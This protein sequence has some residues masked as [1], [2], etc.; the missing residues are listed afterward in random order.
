MEVHNGRSA[1]VKHARNLGQSVPKSG[2]GVDIYMRDLLSICATTRARGCRAEEK[3][4]DKVNK[5]F[6]K[7]T[8]VLCRYF[9]RWRRRFISPGIAILPKERSYTAE[10]NWRPKMMITFVLL[11]SPLV[12]LHD[13][14]TVIVRQMLSAKPSHSE[15]LWNF[16][17]YKDR[18]RITLE[19]NPHF[20]SSLPADESAYTP[21]FKCR[22]LG[23]LNM[24]LKPHDTV[25]VL[26]DRPGRVFLETK[27][28]KR[29]FGNVW[30]LNGTLIFKDSSGILEGEQFVRN[31]SIKGNWRRYEEPVVFHNCKCRARLN[32]RRLRPIITTPLVNPASEMPFDDWAVLSHPSSH[33]INIQIYSAQRRRES[34]LD[35]DLPPPPPTS[36]EPEYPVLYTSIK[37]LN[38][39]VLL[40][41]FDHYRP[42]EERSRKLRLG[43]FK[44]AHV[45]RRWRHLI[46]QSA[47]Y[48]D[49]HIL[50]TKG[51]PVVDTLYLL[52]P[53]PL[54]IDFQSTIIRA[55]DE[56]GISHALRLHNRV[57]RIDLHIP[58][59]SLR[60]SLVLL[61]EPFPRLERLSLSS[62]A[63]EATNLIIPKTFR[64]PNL[65]Y[66][67]LLGINLSNELPLLSSTVSLVTLTLENIRDSGYFLPKHLITCL[68][69]FR[70]LEELSIGFSTPLSHSIAERELLDALESPVTLPKLKIFT[71]SGVGAYLETLIAQIRAP[72]LERLNITLFDQVAF[73]LPH[74]SHFTNTTESLTLPVAEIIFEREAVAVVTNHCELR[75]GNIPSSFSLRVMCNVFDRQVDCAAQ[76]C[77]AL[78]P[79][80]SSVEQ[81]TLVDGE[82]MPTNWQDSDIDSAMWRKL[83]R[84]FIGT[85]RLHICRVLLWEIAYALQLG[86]AGLDPGL[87]PGLQELAPDISARD[88]DNSFTSFI[89]ARQV[90]GRPCHTNGDFGDRFSTI[91][92]GILGTPT[93]LTGTLYSAMLNRWDPPYLGWG[94]QDI[95][96]A[97][98]VPLEHNLPAPHAP[99]ARVEHN[100]PRS[101]RTTHLV[102]IQHPPPK[103]IRSRL[104]PSHRGAGS[105]WR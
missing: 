16:S 23:D 63:D 54:V 39:D 46:Y 97:Q 75:L 103:H 3:A 58:P 38:D 11:R 80:L 6:E 95:L 68:R 52:P 48:L 60:K 86:D 2:R 21:M 15:I 7:A 76:I 19:Q 105:A 28:E 64:A 83:L 36:E 85:K 101:A 8:R 59:S 100:P 41:I 51:A 27:R 31:T 49:A 4:T 55:R 20:Y 44:L 12:D 81:L 94:M 18:A 67:K 37:T 1:F 26:V 30:M 104:R 88:T 25:Y 10:D 77:S 70:Q 69:S 73:A 56:L 90:A 93:L 22:P 40:S 71:F 62:T 96:P 98:P 72:I 99:P 9:E 84:P 91:S 24:A 29:S 78:R 79:A 89:D 87:L 45:C 53:L 34:T 5:R 61:D 32:H 82:W 35:L 43:W 74:L 92:D 66:L 50:C 102:G 47:F 14:E 57:R 17:R 42:D 13:P 65:R 33:S